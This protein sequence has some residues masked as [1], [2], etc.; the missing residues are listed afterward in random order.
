MEL[1]M[2]L[3][4]AASL[5]LAIAGVIAIWQ[6]VALA[7]AQLESQ[8]NITLNTGQ[9]SP[10]ADIL[11]RI[12]KAVTIGNRIDLMHLCFDYPVS[13]SEENIFVQLN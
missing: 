13:S 10:I 1:A 7:E 6:S 11:S 2:M 9:L 3:I 12:E 4:A 5:G 8:T